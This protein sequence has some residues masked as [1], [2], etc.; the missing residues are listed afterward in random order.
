MDMSDRAELVR[1]ARDTMAHAKGR[2]LRQAAGVVRFKADMFT[3]PERFAREKAL[4]FR[5]LPLMLAMSC[6]IPKP[7]DYKSIDAADVPVLIVRGKD[8]KVRAFLNSCTHR[9]A[10]LASGCGNA[11]AVFSCPYH[12]WSFK[13]D[14]SLAGIAAREDFGDVDMARLGLKAFPVLEKAGMVWVVLN[15]ASTLDIDAFLSGYDRLLEA[16]GFADWN[17]VE[18]RVLK[19]ANWKMA[20]DGYLD[21]YHLPVLHRNTFG[22]GCNRALYYAYGPHQ[23]IGLGTPE[24]PPPEPVNVYKIEDRPDS[25]WPLE[26]MVNRGVWTIFP[27]IS[28]ATFY[29]DDGVRVVMLSQLLPGATVGESLTTQ[30][31]LTP[32]QPDDALRGKVAVVSRFLENVV[33]NEDYVT[34]FEQQ[35]ALASGLVDYV[36]YGRNEGGQQVFHSWVDKLLR[37]P[38]EDLNALFSAG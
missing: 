33:A 22:I 21:F 30:I 35:K 29:T 3:D 7:G 6:E 36:Y 34:T 19:G 14:G 23:H 13:L 28:M 20:F 31:F 25:E 32:A 1:V 9:G 26:A 38:D 37:T 5:R 24:L 10:A 27:H 16:F 15:P 11:R 17:I 12:G 2:T 4:I 18:T 8:G